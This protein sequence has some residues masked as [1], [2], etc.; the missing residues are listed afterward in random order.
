MR[1]S[2]ICRIPGRI[3]F[4]EVNA[5]NG[6]LTSLRP[7]TQ[8]PAGDG[9]LWLSPGLFD[10]QV[11]GMFGT[12]FS[13]PDLTAEKVREIGEELERRG[14]TRW[15]PTVTTQDPR[16]VE[17]SLGILADVIE[18]N[19]AP[20]IHGI[21]LEGHYISSEEGYRGVHQEKFIRDPDPD[22]FDRWLRASRGRVCLFSLAPERKGAIEFIQRLTNAGIKVGLVH[23]HADHDTVRA[24]VA[25]GADLSS[26]LI[27]GC[28]KMIHRQHNVIWSQLSID[29][30]WSSFIADGFHIPSYTLR[31]V[32]KARGIDRS[33]LVSDLAGLAG[34]PDGEYVKNERTVVLKDGGLWVKGEGTNL[35]SGAAK[36]LEQDCEYL[37]AYSGFSI[38]EALLMASVNPARYFGIED[39]MQLFPGKKTSLVAFSWGN[40]K[41]SVEKV[42]K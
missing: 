32:I 3:G 9:C 1:F 22:E 39:Q 42:L 24:A 5:D 10:I 7:V 15:C 26:H 40:N 20:N 8:A 17:R 25:A 29:E 33:I 2:E 14:I 6:V 13:S 36:T 37:A 31:A 28:A 11:N 34:L 30:L 23:H 38:E 41:L 18:S 27:N 19:Q 12:P 4:F 35:L 21:H 16:I